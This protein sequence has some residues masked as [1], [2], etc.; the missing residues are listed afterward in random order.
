LLQ[1][2]RS[3]PNK[4]LNTEAQSP[5]RVNLGF[6]SRL[7][8]SLIST[9]LPLLTS[10][11]FKG[12]VRRGMGSFRADKTHPHPNPP[13]ER[14]GVLMQSGRLVLF[15]KVKDKNILFTILETSFC[16]KNPMCSL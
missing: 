14:E 12:E 7:K 11:P 13:L 15:K 8:V 4:K 5:Q 1:G 16:F 10:S 3:K 9:N 6:N 2:Q